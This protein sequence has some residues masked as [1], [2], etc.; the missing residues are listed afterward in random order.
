MSADRGIRPLRG[1]RGPRGA[2]PPPLQQSI[3][4]N[5]RA[6]LRS[7]P[8]GRSPRTAS[9]MN[10]FAKG[11]AVWCTTLSIGRIVA[12]S[13]LFTRSSSRGTCERRRSCASTLSGPSSPP[14][15]TQRSACRASPRSRPT[16]SLADG[17]LSG[18]GSLPRV[19]RQETHERRVQGP[20]GADAPARRDPR[21]ARRD[22]GCR[23]RV[24]PLA[25]PARSAS[26]GSLPRA[27]PGAHEP[28]RTHAAW[29][30]PP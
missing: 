14:R 19:E 30:A 10:L 18:P 26:K 29:L 15:P 8:S 23:F 17:P 27:E 9:D 28:A 1:Y 5:I 20:E 13:R 2:Y 3:L 6:D 25:P 12:L 24:G 22:R 4:S 11:T 16:P 7:A 21:A